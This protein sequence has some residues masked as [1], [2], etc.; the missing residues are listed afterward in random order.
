VP[1]VVVLGCG[2]GVGKTRVS[3]AL[4]RGLSRARLPT[5]GLKPIESGIAVGEDNPPIGS[6]AHDL[7]RA[8]SVQPALNHPLFAFPDPISPHAAARAQRL[9]I[10]LPAVVSWV[11]LAEQCVTPLVSSDMAR[12][13]VIETAGGVFSPLSPRAT[14]FDLALALEPAIWIVVVADSLGALHEASATLQAMRA[15][16][17]EPNH[18]VL[19]AAREPDAS[20]GSNAHE[21]STL[22]IVTPAATL[23]RNDDHGIDA[24]VQLL[25]TQAL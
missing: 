22:G 5:I 23:A 7:A 10:A 16:G 13:S 24:L 17:R 1:R 18:V 25:L 20:T 2:T 12:W 8:G 21:L 15:R 19:S 3:V 6:D 14:N 11:E 9:E 4:L